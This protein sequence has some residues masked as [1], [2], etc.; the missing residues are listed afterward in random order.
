MRRAADVRKHGLALDGGIVA[1]CPVFTDGARPQLVFYWDN[2]ALRYGTLSGFG[3]T[4]DV[5]YEMAY[6]AIDAAA[7]LLR[8]ETTCS[9]AAVLLQPGEELPAH[10]SRDLLQFAWFTAWRAVRELP[11][12]LFGRRS[13]ATSGRAKVE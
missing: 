12:R 4:A 11:G 8:G 6:L 1:L 9:M 5:L 13:R 3:V 2:L 7:A 10:V